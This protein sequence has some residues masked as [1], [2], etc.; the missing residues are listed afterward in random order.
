[1]DYNG[2]QTSVNMNIHS[3]NYRM[4]VSHVLTFFLSFFPAGLHWA[5]IH[6]EL[7]NLCCINVLHAVRVRPEAPLMRS[8][9]STT[10]CGVTSRALHSAI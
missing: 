6:A 4:K 3:G 9:T 2:T 5:Q 8:L 10:P 1:M 7:R